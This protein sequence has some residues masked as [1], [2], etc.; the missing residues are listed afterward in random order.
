MQ[1]CSCSEFALVFS[2][3]LMYGCSAA[4]NAKGLPSATHSCGSVAQNTWSPSA[5]RTARGKEE[6]S[7][8]PSS[9]SSKS[10]RP[11]ASS[12]ESIP[13]RI[14]PHS[15]RAVDTVS[16][17]S[18]RASSFASSS[19]GNTTL[20]RMATIGKVESRGSLA[21]PTRLTPQYTS[22]STATSCS[23]RSAVGSGASAPARRADFVVSA[24]AFENHSSRKMRTMS[25]WIPTSSSRMRNARNRNASTPCLNSGAF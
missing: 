6:M 20:R 17:K 9:L 2:A 14:A 11:S 3:R 18:P 21:Y 15:R 12:C 4:A 24:G 19:A 13:S 16:A 5:Y 1:H 10:S 8:L 25:S 23:A 7:L 22:Q